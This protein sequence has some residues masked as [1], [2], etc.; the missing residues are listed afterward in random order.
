MLKDLVFTF[1]RSG[2]GHGAK[3]EC[4]IAGNLGMQ[5]ANIFLLQSFVFSTLNLAY[6]SCDQ[7]SEMP[8]VT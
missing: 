5:H 7:N 6:I 3:A 4:T 8:P 1:L 2:D